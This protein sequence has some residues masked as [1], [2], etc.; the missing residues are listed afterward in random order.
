MHAHTST[1]LGIPGHK[2]SVRAGSTDELQQRKSLP[3]RRAVHR[4]A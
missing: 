3:C 4:P 1:P 2:Y